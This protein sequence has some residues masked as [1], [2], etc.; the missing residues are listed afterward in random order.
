MTKKIKKLILFYICRPM[1]CRVIHKARNSWTNNTMQKTQTLL[2][3][4]ISTK[5]Y[6]QQPQLEPRLLVIQR[7]QIQAMQPGWNCWKHSGT[8]AEEIV[9]RLARGIASLTQQARCAGWKWRETT[10]NTTTITSNTGHECENIISDWHD[11]AHKK[12]LVPYALGLRE[13]T[14]KCPSRGR[15]RPKSCYRSVMDL[16]AN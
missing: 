10:I 11:T 5:W 1:N 13:R 7:L 9:A 8:N 16:N 4:Q 3:N 2:M 14:H 15:E 6:R 12:C